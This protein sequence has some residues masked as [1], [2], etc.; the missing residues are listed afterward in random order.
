MEPEKT[1]LKTLPSG[2]IDIVNDGVQMFLQFNTSCEDAL[3]FCRG[4]CCAYRPMYNVELKKTE[5]GKGFLEITMDHLPGRTFLDYFVNN[6]H[7]MEHLKDASCRIHHIKPEACKIT[8]CS[9]EG[10]GEG[11][12]IRQKGWRLIPVL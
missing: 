9:P 5:L 12:T 11:I 6:G 3:P 8:H 2:T 4:M 10:K 7:C 1:T